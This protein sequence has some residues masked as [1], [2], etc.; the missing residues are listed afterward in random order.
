MLTCVKTATFFETL[1][2]W[3]WSIGWPPVYSRSWL[4]LTLVMPNRTNTKSKAK[5]KFICINIRISVID[6]CEVGD[7]A[8]NRESFRRAVKRATFY[9]RQASWRRWRVS[10]EYVKRRSL[11]I[12]LVNR[13][14]HSLR[15]ER[16]YTLLNSL[17]TFFNWSVGKE[18][19]SFRQRGKALCREGL[20]S[21]N[22]DIINTSFFYF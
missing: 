19:S 15:T 11:Q 20:G 17:A 18:N 16:L 7:L 1:I 2:D 9:K 21:N 8:R 4:F 10:E 6:I 3:T 13:V 14:Y 12:W 22:V 5:A